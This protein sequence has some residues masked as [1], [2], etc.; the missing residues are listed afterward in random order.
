MILDNFFMKLRIGKLVLINIC[1]IP[2]R[3]AIEKEFDF[4]IIRVSHDFR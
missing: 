4:S 2:L 1:I 3:F